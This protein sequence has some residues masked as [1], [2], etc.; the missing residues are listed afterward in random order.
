[1]R[2]VTMVAPGQAAGALA[3]VREIPG[4]TWIDF[5]GWRN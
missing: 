3:A 1:M 5:S 4:K 2:A